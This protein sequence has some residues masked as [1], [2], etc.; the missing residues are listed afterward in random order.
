M[1]MKKLFLVFTA[2]GFLAACNSNKK[3]ASTMAGSE[4]TLNTSNT[5]NVSQVNEK[6][7]TGPGGSKSHLDSLMNH[8]GA[9]SE[10][11]NHREGNFKG[12]TG[13]GTG[14]SYAGAG[15]AQARYKKKSKPK[16]KRYFD[17]PL[18]QEPEAMK[19]MDTTMLNNGSTNITMPVDSNNLNNELSDFE[20][21][22]DSTSFSKGD[23]TN[24]N[25]GW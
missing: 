12:A 16:V 15:Y 6:N 19:T 4:E 7:V 10:R 9:S 1:D 11:Y 25:S 24:L 3:S 14:G 2:I 20:N 13:P 18:E 17:A 21:S 5:N 8:S 22:N 23:S